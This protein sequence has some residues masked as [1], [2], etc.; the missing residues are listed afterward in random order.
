MSLPVLDPK[1]PTKR[2]LIVI[3]KAAANPK[4]KGGPYKLGDAGAMQVFE[5]R[6]R[7]VALHN[8]YRSKEAAARRKR[9]ALLGLSPI[10]N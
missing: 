8:H 6:A 4:R 7:A 9:F 3:A 10:S 5:K 2:D 1:G